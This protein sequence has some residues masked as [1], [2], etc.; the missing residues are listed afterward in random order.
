MAK[1]MTKIWRYK[2][3]NVYPANRN[4][5][6]IRWYAHSN[7]G[8]FRSDTKESMRQLIS[9]DLSK[10][11]SGIPPH[12]QEVGFPAGKIYEAL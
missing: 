9:R 1:I 11:R 12:P 5:S 8:Y 6:G 10:W 7:A 3:K 4:S 2:G